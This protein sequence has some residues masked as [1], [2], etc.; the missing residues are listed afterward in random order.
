MVWAE[1]A[2]D[3]GY[4]PPDVVLRVLHHLLFQLDAVRRVLAG[5]R[6]L[7]AVFT[8]TCRLMGGSAGFTP[9]RSG[10]PHSRSFHLVSTRW[11]LF[12]LMPATLPVALTSLSALAAGPGFVQLLLSLLTPDLGVTMVPTFPGHFLS[13]SPFSGTLRVRLGR[14]LGSFMLFSL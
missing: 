2:V 5:R 4:L 12:L 6:L 14:G 7:G 8:L 1:S 13:L 9:V 11:F 3:G 10:Q